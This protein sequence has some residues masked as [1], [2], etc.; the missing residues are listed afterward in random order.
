M[1]VEL[2]ATFLTAHGEP[3]PAQQV[4]L[5][6]HAPT[7]DGRR[8]SLGWDIHTFDADH[9]T[10]YWRVTST[11]PYG[12]ND[13]GWQ[14]FHIDRTPPISSITALPE[15]IAETKFTVQWGGTDTLSGINWYHVQV[16]DGSR[17]DSQWQEWLV[18][19][20]KRAEIFSDLPGHT[21]YFRVRAMDKIGNWEVW[22]DGDTHTRVDPAVALDTLWWNSGYA[23]RRNLTILNSDAQAIP[24]HFPVLIRFDATTTPRAAEIYQSSLATSKGNDVRIVYN[25]QVE[26][27]RVIYKFTSEMVEI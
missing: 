7:G 21:Y 16:R 20:T 13:G 17:S 23:R 3:Q 24:S 8:V 12:T 22:P 6:D 9:P 15:A 5:W 18:N 25:N 2:L 19:T 10:V 1:P 14:R 26:L 11:G 4:H 27:D